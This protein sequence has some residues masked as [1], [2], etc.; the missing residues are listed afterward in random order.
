L[1]MKSV[2]STAEFTR[3]WT[4]PPS[5]WAVISSEESW[6][7]WLARAL[8]NRSAVAGFRSLTGATSSVRV[9]ERSSLMQLSLQI[10]HSASAVSVTVSPGF[11]DAGAV[12][13]IRNTGLPENTK[14][15]P[16]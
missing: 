12:S 9:N 16:K 5:D 8:T 13:S 11:N 15:L 10:C 7:G 2:G 4:S 14:L 6:I 3:N 1:G